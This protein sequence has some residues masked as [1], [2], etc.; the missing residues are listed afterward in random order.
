MNT[1]PVAHHLKPTLPELPPRIA[2]L[3]VDE[4]GYPV[5]FFVAWPDG[6]PEFR[7]ADGLKLAR[8]HRE[9]LCWVCGEKLGKYMTFAIGP[10]CSIN[11]ISA[12]PPSHRDCCEWYVKGCPFLS[13]PQMVRRD[14]DGLRE[15]SGHVEPAGLMIERNP[16]VTMLWTTL[17]Y[18]LTPDHN[19]RA[20][21][22][23]G[24]PEHISWWREGRPA[25][26]AEVLE[27]IETGLPHLLEVCVEPGSREALELAKRRAMKLIPA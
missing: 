22:A 4:R 5:P 11:R 27:S 7:M 10:M 15:T 23:I 26:R 20:L 24:E 9:K 2:K 14:P 21:F 18:K 13:K 1:C 16:G 12:E 19:G 6:K 17:S 8:C 3:P 25:T